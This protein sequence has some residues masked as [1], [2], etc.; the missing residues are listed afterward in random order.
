MG[1]SWSRED[2]ATLDEEEEDVSG[3][4]ILHVLRNL[5]IMTIG[6]I[7]HH[8]SISFMA[9][10]ITSL[11]IRSYVLRC[12]LASCR[13]ILTAQYLHLLLVIDRTHMEGQFKVISLYK[14]VREIVHLEL[15]LASIT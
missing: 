12:L 11:L 7:I 10:S 3:H 13:L 15:V 4:I 14:L 6:V 9:L 1:N 2:L 5:L 8:S